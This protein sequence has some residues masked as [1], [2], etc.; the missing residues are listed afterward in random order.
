MFSEASVAIDGSKFKAVNT[1]DR[2]FTQAKMERRLA[3]ID[4]SIARYLSQLDSADRQGEAVP[5]AR[6]TRLNEKIA[7]LRQEIGRLNQLNSRMMESEDKQ[8]SLTDPDAR[9]MATSGRGS[10]M[11]GYN[12]QSAVDTRHHLIVAHEVTNVGSDRDQLS[13]MTERARLAIGSEAIEVVADRGY[14]KGEEIVAC[15]QAG[16]TVYLPKPMTSGVY[17]KGRFGKQDFVYVAADD[18]YRCPAGEQ[19]TYHYTNQQ[20]GK[21]LR[22]YWTTACEACALKS[23]CTTGKERRISRWEHEAVLEVVQARLDR[24]PEKMRLRRQSV[25]HPFGTIKSWMGSTHFQMKRLKNVSTEMALHVLAYN[26]KWVIRLL[27]VG[28]FMEAIRA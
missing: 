7:A 19:L 16:N 12:V 4:E 26:M 27:G 11:V 9:S 1:R 3:Q 24:S 6:I 28:G 21:E 20:D 2:N 14:Y 15:E 17:A 18:I 22:R 5:E 13:D 25:E 10:G 8:I 23:K